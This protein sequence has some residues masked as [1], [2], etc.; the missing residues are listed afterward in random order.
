MKNYIQP[1]D[2]LTVTAPYDVKAGEGVLVGNLF[3]VAT[4]DA[5]SGELVTIV[6]KGAFDLKK[7]SAQ[8]WTAGA[9]VYW[10]DTTKE[11]TS[12]ASGN[13]LVGAAVNAA[14]DPSAT[15]AVLLDG[16]VR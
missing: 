6:R 1:G 8:A 2:N 16:A 15:G 14:A 7:T 3:G 10:N 4:S 11:C 9:K 12:A 13:K 5:A